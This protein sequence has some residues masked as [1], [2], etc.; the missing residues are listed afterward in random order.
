VYSPYCVF[1]VAWELPAVRNFGECLFVEQQHR[2]LVCF[3]LLSRV[4]LGGLTNKRLERVGRWVSPLL[5]S[6]D[7][8]LVYPFPFFDTQDKA[9]F[10]L[11]SR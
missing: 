11:F 3:L 5:R 7:A 4:L 8:Y 2:F 10:V 9:C 1:G 6:W